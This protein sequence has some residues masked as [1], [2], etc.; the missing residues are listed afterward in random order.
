MGQAGDMQEYGPPLM[1]G[2]GQPPRIHTA[3]LNCVS[4]TETPVMI[5]RAPWLSSLF[6][7]LA[8]SFTLTIFVFPKRKPDR[9]LLTTPL[10]RSVQAAVTKYHRLGGL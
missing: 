8:P 6:A 10:Y 3:E 1:S 2:P 7:T 5:V 4:I 9:D